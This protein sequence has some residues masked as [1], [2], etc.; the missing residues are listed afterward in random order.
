MPI[1]R[2]AYVDWSKDVYSSQGFRVELRIAVFDKAKEKQRRFFSPPLSFV[3]GL[4]KVKCK[5]SSYNIILNNI[6]P[7]D[8]NK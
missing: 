7:L 2:V 5:N 8:G 3:L 1:G 4:N 6:L